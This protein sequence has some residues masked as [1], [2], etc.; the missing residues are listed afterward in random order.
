MFEAEVIGIQNYGVF[1]KFD[2]NKKGLVHISEIQSGFVNDI[3][4][5][6]EI[7]QKIKVQVFDY[8]EY[9][10]KISLSCRTLEENQEIH[11]SKRKH[12]VTDGQTKIGFQ[13]ISKELSTW[14]K[15]SEE[16]LKEYSKD[17]LS[18]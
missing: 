4:E 17:D 8:D 15:E 13:S 7:G 5:S 9:S 6:V 14:I 3:Y 11:K 1:V 16:Y 18:I 12:F 10:E 2:K